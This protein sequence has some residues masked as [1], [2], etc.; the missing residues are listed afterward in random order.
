MFFLMTTS[1]LKCINSV[2]NLTVVT[3][4]S[5][6]INFETRKSSQLEDHSKE[7]ID[8]IIQKN[9][10]FRALEN[11]ILSML[12]DDQIYMRELIVQTILNS[13]NNKATRICIFKVPQLNF[14]ADDY[15]ELART[16]VD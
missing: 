7:I 9:T 5:N 1:Y 6:F 11:I 10:Y 14:N 12:V 2:L 16:R 4:E 15:T 13:K 3:S 8:S